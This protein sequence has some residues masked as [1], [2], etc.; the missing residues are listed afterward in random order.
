VSIDSITLEYVCSVL[1]GD[2]N[3]TPHLSVASLMPMITEV[4]DNLLRDTV[5]KDSKS[6]DSRPRPWWRLAA[7]F[8]Y[9]MILYLPVNT[10]C[11]FGTRTLK[12][13]CFRAFFC[14]KKLQRGQFTVST[15]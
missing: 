15:L 12:I 13:D 11:N 2:V 3:R 4:M 1:L 14:S 7:I 10:A 6:Y 8:F 5:A 9:G